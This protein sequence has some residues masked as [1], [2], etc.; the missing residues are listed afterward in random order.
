MTATRSE[1]NEA[2]EDQSAPSTAYVAL[3]R[4]AFP[5]A[6]LILAVL[7]FE[8][9]YGRFSAEN[10]Y[11]PYFVISLLVVLIGTVYWD[12][13]GS[14]YKHDSDKKFT[15]SLKE[16]INE[17]QRSI[18]VVV[19]GVVYLSLVDVVGFFISSF[20]SMIAIMI[21]G[22]A[23]NLKMIIG[24]TV[25]VLALIYALFVLVMSLNPPT[26]MEI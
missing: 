2:V 20:F 22:E 26:G 1:E 7:Y 17:W 18:G 12:E 4:L 10:V 9:T 11:Y 21:I 3:V 14:L 13:I 19:I 24:S 5:T 15:Q 16:S 6:A 8:N 23:R 25:L